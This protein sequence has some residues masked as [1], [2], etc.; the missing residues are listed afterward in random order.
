M[1]TCGSLGTFLGG[2]GQFGVG[3]YVQKTLTDVAHHT[4]V[5]VQATFYKIDQWN[6]RQGVLL[7]DGMEVWRSSR[8]WQH[9][10]QDVVRGTYGCGVIGYNQGDLSVEMDVTFDHYSS[11]L[12]LR[13]TS[14]LDQSDDYCI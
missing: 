13:F 7:A 11:N 12:T 6:G 5:R 14:T 10:N 9:S 3:A 4:G 1:T 2:Y 8:Y